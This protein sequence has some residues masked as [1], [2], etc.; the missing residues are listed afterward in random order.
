MLRKIPACISPDLMHALMS[1]GHGEEIVLADA[2]FPA[3]AHARRIIR[4]DGVE[5]AAL[6]EAILPFFPLDSFVDRPA[7]T[8]DCSEWGDE[9]ESY[10]RFRKIIRRHN[11]KFTD[12]EL[13]K[14]FDL[15]KRAAQAYVVVVTSEADG[16][17][18][19]KK[20]PVMAEEAPA[21]PA[22]IIEKVARPFRNGK[23]TTVQPSRT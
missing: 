1:M 17:V 15:Y 22:D 9:P 6:L 20:G 3:A 11:G 18:I 14:R 19:L 12:F 5:V 23:R 13:L 2:D 16:N 4:A 10:A 21:V 7:I 8:M